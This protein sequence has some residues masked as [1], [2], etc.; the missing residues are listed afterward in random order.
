VQK[1]AV[2]CFDTLWFRKFGGVQGKS[3]KLVESQ[4]NHNPWPC[5]GCIETDWEIQNSKARRVV[6]K[7]N[8]S[9]MKLRNSRYHWAIVIKGGTWHKD[10]SSEE[11][12]SESLGARD[13]DIPE[14]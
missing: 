6:C 3:C 14:A 5:I 12:A 9:F 8:R 4:S 7:V 1:L 13:H 2:R 10:Q 11:N